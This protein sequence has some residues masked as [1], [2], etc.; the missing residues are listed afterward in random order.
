[1]SGFLGAYDS[2]SVIMSAQSTEQAYGPYD[3]SDWSDIQFNAIPAAATLTLKVMGSFSHEVPD[4]DS[5]AS[6]S[7]RWFYVGIYNVST[8]G[9]VINGETGIVYSNTSNSRSYMVNAQRLKWLAFE[10]SSRSGG[11][12]TVELFKSFN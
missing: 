9:S 8:D 6:A 10:I 4:F 2:G 7:N 3:V 11:A 5:A 1:M 12:V